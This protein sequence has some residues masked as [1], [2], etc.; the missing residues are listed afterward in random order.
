MLRAAYFDL[1]GVL[2]R[3]D[4]AGDVELE[5]AAGLPAGAIRA[6]AFHPDLLY[7]AITGAVTDEAWRA[8]IVERLRETFPMAD[9]GMAVRVWSE[10][11]GEVVTE[12][13]DVVREYRGRLQ[14]GLLTNATS[15]LPSDLQRLGLNREFDVVVNSSVVGV[16]K[17]DAAIYAAALAHVGCLPAETFFVDDSMANV[18]A[19]RASGWAA[20]LFEDAAGLR[21]ALRALVEA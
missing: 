16:M 1:D 13:L 6:V 2:R 8:R 7:P 9:A 19:A 21:H 10:P 18:E 4:G 14:V 5:A 12:V 15:R 3:W 20:H 11:I 17:P